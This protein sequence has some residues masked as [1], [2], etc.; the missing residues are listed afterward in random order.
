MGTINRGA[1]GLPGRTVYYQDCPQS[2]C[3]SAEIVKKCSQCSVCEDAKCDAWP[4]GRKR[5]ALAICMYPIC[6]RLCG[7]DK[8]CDI[9]LG[10]GKSTGYLDIDGFGARSVEPRAATIEE[11]LERLLFLTADEGF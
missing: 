9:C 8:I 3:E 1:G 5:I 4:S 2:H 7:K 10:T 6:D 11:R